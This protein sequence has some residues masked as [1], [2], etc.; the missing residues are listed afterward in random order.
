MLFLLSFC[1]YITLFDYIK[2]SPGRYLTA[3]NHYQRQD[4]IDAIRSMSDEQLLLSFCQDFAMLL[5]YDCLEGISENKLA[6]IKTSCVQEK[7][8]IFPFLSNQVVF[9][10]FQI[11]VWELENRNLDMIAA[12]ACF[13]ESQIK[14]DGQL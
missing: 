7:K 5:Q 12:F 14:D 9:L 2:L 1:D 3:M 13:L 10:G 6:Q 4:V 11:S 8:S